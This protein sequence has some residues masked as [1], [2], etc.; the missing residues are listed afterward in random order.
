METRREFNVDWQ[1]YPLPSKGFPPY[2]WDWYSDDET[3]VSVQQYANEDRTSVISKPY[4]NPNPYVIYM[5]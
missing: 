4:I 2:N 5:N 3:I 1:Q